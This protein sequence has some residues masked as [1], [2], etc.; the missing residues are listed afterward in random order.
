MN[1]LLFVVE[2]TAVLS[3]EVRYDKLAVRFSQMEN[4]VVPNRHVSEKDMAY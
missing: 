1:Y 3:V 4:P 2:S